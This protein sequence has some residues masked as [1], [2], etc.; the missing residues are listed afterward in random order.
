MTG[1]RN[2]KDIRKSV[3]LNERYKDTEVTLKDK[4]KCDVVVASL[5]SNQVARV[6]FSLLAPSPQQQRSSPMDSDISDITCSI[7]VVVMHT[8][9]IR[10]RESFNST[11]E[12]QK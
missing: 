5:T 1:G 11:M 2:K 8:S 12:Y 4:C 9:L 6:R 10:M 3:L 7:G